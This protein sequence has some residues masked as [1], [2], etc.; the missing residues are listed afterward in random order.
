MR[1]KFIYAVA[2]FCFCTFTT[3]QAQTNY[4][5]GLKV[6]D[7]A[8]DFSAKDQNGKMVRLKDLRKKGD[9]VIIFYRGQ[10]CPFCNQQLKK[11]N[12]S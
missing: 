10:W 11:V 2:F 8:P 12:R 3:L 4:P 9:V 5:Q 1:N 6:G 7:I